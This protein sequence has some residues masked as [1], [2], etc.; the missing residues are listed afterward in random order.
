MQTKLPLFLKW[1][2]VFGEAY[3][4]PERAAREVSYADRLELEQEIMRRRDDWEDEDEF[5]KP[6]ME[7]GSTSR[8]GGQA[9]APAP[10]KKG[11]RVLPRRLPLRT[12]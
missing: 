1:G 4:V 12:D 5:E 10:E 11:N 6:P 8:R 3:E 7:T 2:I 9:H